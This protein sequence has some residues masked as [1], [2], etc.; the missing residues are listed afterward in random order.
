MS[1]D[2]LTTKYG[3]RHSPLCLALRSGT[4]QI[5][6]SSHSFWSDIRWFLCLRLRYTPFH[7]IKGAGKTV[8]TSPSGDSTAGGIPA[9]GGWRQSLVFT[10]LKSRVSQFWKFIE[11]DKGKCTL[12]YCCFGHHL[13]LAYKISACEVCMIWRKPTETCKNPLPIAESRTGKPAM[14]ALKIQ[15]NCSMVHDMTLWANI[16]V[17]SHLGCGTDSVFIRFCRSHKYNK[18]ANRCK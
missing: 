4:A 5:S 12:F 14:V 7:D 16:Y 3:W 17:R 18:D 1:K 15:P 2:I 13:M 11:H 9:H 8:P 10:A 6:P